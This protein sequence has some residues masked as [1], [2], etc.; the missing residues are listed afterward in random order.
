M[1][2]T[3]MKKLV[4]MLLAFILIIGAV[5]VSCQKPEQPNN[6][7]D[8]TTG[9]NEPGTSEQNDS[10]N[11]PEVDLDGYDFTLFMLEEN[12]V[13][14]WTFES[15]GESQE[16]ISDALY[17]R[18]TKVEDRFNFNFDVVGSDG[19][20]KTFGQIEKSILAGDHSYDLLAIHNYECATALLKSRYLYDMNSIEYLDFDRPW[21]HSQINSVLQV[22][23][24]LPF[25]SS[26]FSLNSFQYA[27]AL[28]FN[29]VLAEDANLQ[30]KYG[31]SMYDIIS[32]G[33]WTF[34]LFYEMIGMFT[35][36]V[37]GDTLMNENDAY[38]FASN[39]TYHLNTWTYAG[40]EMGIKVSNDGELTFNY[41]ERF[42][43]IAEKVYSILFSSGYTFEII[44]GMEC[45][46][47]WDSN[48][49][50]IQAVWLSE[51]EN[52]R[53]TNIEYGVIPFP[54]LDEA[55]KQYQTYVDACG[56]VFAVPIDHLNTATVGLV[57]EAMS[58]E[59]HVTV[60]PAYYDV[61]LKYKHMRDEESIKMLDMIMEGRVWDFGYIYPE[62]GYSV[63]LGNY[64][65][66]S[67]GKMSSVLKK[68]EKQNQVFY[69]DI[70]AAYKTM[71]GRFS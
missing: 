19:Y 46:I 20:G 51:L 16:T 5:L 61:V 33:E 31:K 53:A 22:Y 24:Y 9:T 14:P 41:T 60:I 15:D 6:S 36:D 39:F 50:F 32:D 18:N 1:E 21:W 57:L 59:S 37:N 71:A 28:I 2:F 52:F 12:V 42:Y 54:K 69:E 49:I 13:G 45:T 8:N 63:A 35:N 56:L 26:D 44:H 47:P 40:N 25:A 17:R 7:T 58:A 23:D 27:H 43:D 48:R 68:I 70:I 64:L 55:Q 3:N 30:D 29:K 65:R 62:G 67:G 66:G 34:D 10:D 11:L 38:G 4:T